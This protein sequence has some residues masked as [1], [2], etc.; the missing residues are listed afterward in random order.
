MAAV[1]TLIHVA[2]L[3]T[4]TRRVGALVVLVCALTVVSAV[5]PLSALSSS[6]A[7]ATSSAIGSVADVG[8]YLISSDGS[9][10]AVG[11]VPSGGGSSLGGLPHTVAAAA[12]PVGSGYWTVSADGLVVAHDGASFY[13]DTF[14]DGITGLG[15]PH[16]LNAPIVGI[17][18]TSD[19]QGYWLVASDGGIFTFGDAQFH[20]TPYS[21]GI[22][23][24]SGAHP[25]N[26]PI[27]AIIPDPSGEGYRLIG[28]D[29]GV[30]DFGN[31]LFYGSTYSDGITGLSGAHPLS[32]PIVGG[33]PSENGDGYW[34]IGA[35]GGVFTFGNATFSGSTY[36]L[37]YTGLAGS[38]P[39]AAPITS[40]M[41]NPEGSGYY[42]LMSDGDVLAIGG[43]P[44]LGSAGFTGTAVAI[45]PTIPT[46]LAIPPAGASLASSE[47]TSSTGETEALSLNNGASSSLYD[48]SV[49]ADVP[50][51]LSI[52]S[53]GELIDDVTGDAA[54][55][56][57]FDVMVAAASGADPLSLPFTLNYVPSAP[58]TVSFTVTP[59]AQFSESLAS[60]V[61]NGT[62][63]SY[64]L[65]PGAALPSGVSLSDVG[66]LSGTATSAGGTWFTTG[67]DVFYQGN[68]V[69]QSTVS[70]YVTPVPV[71][72]ANSYNWA[73][74][75][76]SA[77]GVSQVSGTLVVPTLSAVQDST[78]QSASSSADD[79][80]AIA[81]WVGIDG[82]TNDYLIQAGVQVVAQ[83]GGQVGGEQYSSTETV[84]PWYEVITP[85]N[86]E[87]EQ[88]IPA[89]LFAIS[90]GESL[91]VEIT[92]LTTG[93]WVIN[94][95]NEATGATYTVPTQIFSA[96]SVS[97]ESVEWISETPNYDPQFSVVPEVTSGG[98]FTERGAI[99]DTLSASYA[100]SLDESET[101]AEISPTGV[102]P[103]FNMDGFGFS[104]AQ[105][106]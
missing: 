18:A 10:E 6:S 105:S 36:S 72:L 89:S 16:P 95:T 94:L 9:S 34:M 98:N 35:D 1:R 79:D 92:R 26:A 102:G 32:A 76:D 19:G 31:A 50:S 57:D 96:S 15:G 85:S 61:E 52:T 22:T 90:P 23:G 5:T 68:G 87:P 97:P 20:G 64:S 106:S 38:H 56:Y 4:S 54:V 14:S 82:F 17:A 75:V 46:S 78:C 8:Y 62:L 91:S 47:W 13:G 28:K 74:V 41:A 40:F 83:T 63:F 66:V 51:G 27:T 44:S 49:A 53:A 30:F 73:G 84:V 42:L 88:A 59:E 7:A 60:E 99:F 58:S 86:A 77:S 69:G 55:T 21:D 70:V 71:G 80:C 45:V 65:A 100:V 104:Y 33:S 11:Y 43:A 101:G 81:N 12:N 93:E 48:W 37:G 67:V 3:L 29:G 103:D 24:L 2:A 39:L 25:L